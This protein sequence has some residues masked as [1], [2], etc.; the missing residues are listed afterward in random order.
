MGIRQIKDK[1]PPLQEILEAIAHLHGFH[2][3]RT[4]VD[5]YWESEIETSKGSLVLKS[6]GTWQW[7]NFH[8][9]RVTTTE[10]IKEIAERN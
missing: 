4:E 1:A 7:R 8:V 10:L 9:E 6:D 3:S 2:P 5:S